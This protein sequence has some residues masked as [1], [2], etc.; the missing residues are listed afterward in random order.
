MLNNLKATIKTTVIYSFGNLSTKLVGLVLIP[1]F[2]SHLTTYE[3][4]IYGILEGVSQIIVA[5]FGLGLYNAFYRWYWDKNYAD[6]KKS[7]FFTILCTVAIL[8]T[9]LTLLFSQFSSYISIFLFDKPEY[10]FLIKFM[11]INTG[12]EA[13]LIIPSTLL[14]LQQRAIHYSSTYLVKFVINLVFSIYFIKYLNH[15]V[16]GIFE[17]QII[18]N[19]IYFLVLLRF[20]IKNIDFKFDSSLLKGML[21]YSIPLIFSS[22]IGVLLSMTDR[23]ALKFL[24]SLS[25]VGIY[26]L[27]FKLANTIK[28]F[29]VASIN[30]AIWPIIFKM[31]DSPDNKRYYSKL[32]TYTSFFILFFVIGFSFLGKEII[33]VLAHQ[34]DYWDAYKVIPVISFSILFGMLKDISAIGLHFTKKTKIF[35]LFIFYTLIIDIGLNLILV[36]LFGIMGAAFSTCVAQIVLFF[37][38]YYN[39]QK[40]Y[41]IPYELKKIFSMILVSIVLIVLATFTNDLY[42]PIRLFLKVVLLFIFPIILY[43]L[44]FYEEVEIDRI[45]KIWIEWRNPLKWKNNLKR[46]N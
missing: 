45:R 31:M 44:G 35:A 2:T 15:K 29:I 32:M 46:F 27:G 6:K 41:F 30:M 8:S 14:R 42:L 3:Y 40:L 24:S 26:S 28:V 5:F 20:I 19:I 10:S 34:T 7:M 37:F 18:G 11:L 22:V 21:K 33:K 16:D 9:I 43:F 36:P 39:S 4:G 1:L 25:D 12:F 38:T 23:F 13:L 17:A